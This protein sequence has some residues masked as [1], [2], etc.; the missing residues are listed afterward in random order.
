MTTQNI[1]W[2]QP[3]GRLAH[4]VIVSQEAPVTSAAHAADLQKNG[5]V[6]ATWVVLAFDY[7]TPLP[8]TPIE[9]WVWNQNGT[10]S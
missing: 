2:K 5:A 6:P 1:I 8:N 9:S 7:S 10:I 4:T 3:S